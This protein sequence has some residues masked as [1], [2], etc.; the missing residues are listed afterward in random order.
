MLQ[1]RAG[2]DRVKG[3][4]GKGQLTE[5]THLET[6]VRHLLFVGKRTGP[7]DHAGLAIHTNDVARGN[8]RSQA[9]SDRTGAAAAVQEAHTRL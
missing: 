6:H 8:G 9:K 3:G 4:R 1:D 5:I 2:K 7:F